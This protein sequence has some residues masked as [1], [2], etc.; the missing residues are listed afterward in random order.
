MLKTRIK[1]TRKAIFFASPFLVS[2]SNNYSDLRWSKNA[3]SGFRIISTRSC[4]VPSANLGKNSSAFGSN[5]PRCVTCEFISRA[6]N[7]LIWYFT[8]PVVVNETNSAYVGI[9]SRITTVWVMRKNTRIH[10][11]AKVTILYY[12]T[13]KK[14]FFFKESDKHRLITMKVLTFCSRRKCFLIQFTR[15]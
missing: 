1:S 15:G 9:L 10:I 4:I 14:V 2:T 13:D 6:N 8:L 3:P 11:Y 7:A 5:K 12:F